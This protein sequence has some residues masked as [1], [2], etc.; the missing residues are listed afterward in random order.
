MNA[1][2]VTG[3]A[4]GFVSVMVSTEGAGGAIAA[5]LKAFAIDGC[6]FTVSVAVAPGAVP[7]FAVVTLPVLLRYAPAVAEVTLTVTVHEPPAGTVPPVS[8][9]LLALLAAVTVP[10]HTS[11]HPRPTPCSRGPRDRYR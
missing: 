4:F 7:A 5:G 9:T 1:A 6:A 8:A 11:S 2:P 10:P 3:E